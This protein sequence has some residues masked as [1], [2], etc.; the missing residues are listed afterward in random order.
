[1]TIIVHRN[2]D[3]GIETLGDLHIDTGIQTLFT[4]KSLELPDFNNDGIAGNEK[5]KSCIPKNTY[6]WVKVGATANIP[7]N[8]IS[9]L[10]IPGRSGV[11]IHAGNYYT[12]I[13]GCIIVGKNHIDINGDGQIDVTE[14]RKTFDKMMELLP[15]SGKL[16]IM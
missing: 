6:D 15:D 9:I 3:N 4:C 11:C 2:S 14:S 7:Y 16:I 1:M 12:Q 10:N 5:G 8:H 13:K